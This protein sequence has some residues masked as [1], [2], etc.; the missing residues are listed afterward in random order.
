MS[1]GRVTEGVEG[2]VEGIEVEGP[3]PIDILKLA[4][5]PPRHGRVA[6]FLDFFISDQKKKSFLFSV[7]SFQEEEMAGF[8]TTD[9]T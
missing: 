2:V 3:L 8:R 7:F 1:K 6:F 9:H 5:V 4:D